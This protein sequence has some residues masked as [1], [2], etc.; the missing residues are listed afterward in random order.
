MTPSGRSATRA[1]IIGVAFTLVTIALAV[2]IVVTDLA[3]LARLGLGVIAG[4]TLI[5]AGV[6]IGYALAVIRM[7][8]EDDDDED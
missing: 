5:C 2:V 4:L 1:A 8:D 6:S 7:R 3:I